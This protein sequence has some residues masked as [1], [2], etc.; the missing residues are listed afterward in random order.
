MIIQLYKLEKC[1]F[2]KRGENEPV[3]GTPSEWF[4]SFTEWVLDRPN[5]M[6]TA[7]FDYRGNTTR[8]VFCTA[9]T[10]DDNGNF[11]VAL[12]NEAPAGEEGVDY[13][14]FSSSVG[15][16]RAVTQPLPNESIPGWPTYLW[17]IPDQLIIAA[18]VPDN[19][20]GFR[21]TGVPQARNYF[22][23]Y[24]ELYSKFVVKA[25]L[26]DGLTGTSD[27]IVGYRRDDSEEPEPKLTAY[28]ETTPLY[29]PRRLGEFLDH[30]SDIRKLVIEAKVSSP[31]P[32]QEN[33]LDRLLSYIGA[34]TKRNMVS[35]EQAKYRLAMD[36][37]PQSQQELDSMI[38]SWESR[39]GGDNY[40]AGVQFKGSS[41]IHWFG[42]ADGKGTV[43]IS[44]NL[45][46]QRLWRGEE[47]QDAWTQASPKVTELLQYVEAQRA[48][49]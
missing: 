40:S 44:N 42:Y 32:S 3:F 15:S 43:E 37:Q 49:S 33:F 38:N 19:M 36:W 28:F 25:R 29:L 17:F 45:S 7:T 30:W 27:E 18:L 12:W 34:S 47:L 24:L 48:T 1:G 39:G 11:G 23:A 46:S 21:S 8:R 20:R 14:P 35:E 4:H 9:T 41:K 16:V 31:L 2:F 10:S 26:V 22:R 5:V 13:I 6:A